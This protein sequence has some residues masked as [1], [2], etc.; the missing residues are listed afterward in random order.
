MLAC[1]KGVD[2]PTPSVANQSLEAEVSSLDLFR[3]QFSASLA[4]GGVSVQC[5]TWSSLR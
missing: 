3:A 2:E 1:S 4:K 5:S